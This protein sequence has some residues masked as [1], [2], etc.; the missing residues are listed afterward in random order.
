MTYAANT[1]FVAGILVGIAL[2]GNAVG[3]CEPGNIPTVTIYMTDKVNM[4]LA[5]RGRAIYVATRAFQSAGVLLNWHEGP[6]TP[7][8]QAQDCAFDE[9]IELQVDATAEEGFTS[10]AMAYATPMETA[11]TRVHVFYD[12]VSPNFENVPNLFGYVLAHEIGHVLEGAPRHSREGILKAKWDGRDYNSM[13][14]FALRFT[15]ED[16]KMIAAGASPMHR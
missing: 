16:V 10:D 2:P 14:M 12:R 9:S 15:P 13:S 7:A 6:M 3:Q 11:G 8:Q 5:I 1:L 4:K